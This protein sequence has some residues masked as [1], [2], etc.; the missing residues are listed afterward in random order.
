MQIPERVK[1]QS[2]WTAFAIAYGSA[3]ALF[4]VLVP[5]IPYVG[6]AATI[7]KLLLPEDSTKPADPPST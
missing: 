3:A 6:L 2:F 4:P 1:R 5:G 7:A